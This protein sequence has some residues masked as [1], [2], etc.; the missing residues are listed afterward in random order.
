[1]FS[2]GEKSELQAGQN[3][4]QSLLLQSHAVV[5]HAF[6]QFSIRAEM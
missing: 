3:S 4:M 1:M 6:M 5:M 2:V